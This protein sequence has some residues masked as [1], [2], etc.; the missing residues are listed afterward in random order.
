MANIGEITAG[1]TRGIC[2]VCETPV[3]GR[4]FYCED[5]KPKKAKAPQPVA[6][7]AGVE[8]APPRPEPRNVRGNPK[9]NDY[10]EVFGPF[11]LGAINS[12]YVIRMLERL[13]D[14]LISEDEAEELIITQRE[15]NSVLLPVARIFATTG[16]SKKYGKS[17][18]E[19]A[20]V[21]DALNSAVS[22][23]M[24]LGK[25]QQLIN[26]TEQ[27]LASQP[28]SPFVGP[29][30]PVSNPGEPIGLFPFGASRP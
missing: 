4:S 20:D 6:E 24:K 30:G 22:I 2:Q 29:V 16:V 21:L 12:W 1:M 7:I 27:Y 8:G 19:N 3:D 26:R 5:H 9:G 17:A 15:F 13:P 11:I 28:Q 18:L 10:V 14:G 23:A 25:L